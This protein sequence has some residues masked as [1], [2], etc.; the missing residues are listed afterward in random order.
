MSWFK[1]TKNKEDNKK[2]LKKKAVIKNFVIFTE[3]HLCRDHNLI[4]LKTFR[5]IPELCDPGP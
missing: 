1:S 5:D 3:K 2:K 4:E